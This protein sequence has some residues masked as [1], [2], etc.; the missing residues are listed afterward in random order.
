MGDRY[1]VWPTYNFAVS[2]DDYL[3]GVTHVLRAQE[4]SVNTIKQSYIFK[5]LG[6]RQPV[7]IHFGR[8]R[9]EGASLK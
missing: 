6:W 7:T 1:I 4:H 2:I 8:L 3:M 9:I 5:H